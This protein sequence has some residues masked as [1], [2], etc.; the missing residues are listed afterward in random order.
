M[1][2][3]NSDRHFNNIGIIADVIRGVYKNAPVFDNG[4]SL[5]SNIG[6]YPFE[7]PAQYYAEKIVGQPFSANLERQAWE[8]GYGLKIDYGKLLRL[9][10]KEPDSRALEILHF[11][12]NRY[13][14]IL[15]I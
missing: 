5:L 2:I 3:L 7:E 13:E 6:E 11:Q 9:L 4:N 12:L 15:K 14:K 8:L 10:E 1:L